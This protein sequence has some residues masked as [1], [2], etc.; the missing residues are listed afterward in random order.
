MEILKKLIAYPLAFIGLGIAFVGI[1]LE[2]ISE[3]ILEMGK[4]KK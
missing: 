4:D 2:Q 3:G 1:M